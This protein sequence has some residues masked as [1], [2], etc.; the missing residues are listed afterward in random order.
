MCFCLCAN[1]FACVYAC[2]VKRMIK[3]ET[4]DPKNKEAKIN[5]ERLV[6]WWWCECVLCR[7]IA[8]E[9]GLKRRCVCFSWC[10]LLKHVHH[11]FVE[12]AGCPSA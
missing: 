11:E 6:D 7:E 1:K 8:R 4:N 3:K 12:P 2:C 9:V 5:G 10:V